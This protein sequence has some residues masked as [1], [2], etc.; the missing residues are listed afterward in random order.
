MPGPT[1]AL[2]LSTIQNAD[3]IFF[4]RD[5]RVAESGTHQEL[6]ALNGGYA[7]LVNMQQLSRNA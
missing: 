3:Q 5:G 1:R 6:L 4:F 2:Q 7:E